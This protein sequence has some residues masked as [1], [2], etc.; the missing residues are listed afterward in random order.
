VFPGSSRLEYVT[1]SK[2]NFEAFLRDLLLVR[3][4]RV[5][6]YVNNGTR[7]NPSWA[8]GHAVSFI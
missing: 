7:A 3:K 4:Y 6:L 5:E 8:L 1:I 2:M